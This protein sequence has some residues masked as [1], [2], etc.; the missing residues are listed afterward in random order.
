[1]GVDSR[2]TR[3]RQEE[4]GEFHGEA[5]ECGEYVGMARAVSDSHDR[6]L[7]AIVL[8][9]TLYVRHEQRLH[10]GNSHWHHHFSVHQKIDLAQCAEVRG[11]ATLLGTLLASL[12]LLVSFSTG[13]RPKL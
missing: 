2:D 7:G 1:M 9:P 6:S 12:A 10:M 3:C 13:S 11:R 5:V 8:G 4:D